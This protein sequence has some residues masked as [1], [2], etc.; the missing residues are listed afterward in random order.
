MKHFLK[1]FISILIC[2]TMVFTIAPLNGMAVFTSA[3]TVSED[4]QSGVEDTFN[5]G[6]GVVKFTGTG[7][8]EKWEDCS[9][10]PWYNYRSH[11]KSVVIGDGVTNI[12]AYVFYDCTNLISVT[13]PASIKN[14]EKQA[15]YNCTQLKEV[16]YGGTKAEWNKISIEEDNDCLLNAKIHFSDSEEVHIHSYKSTIIKD[17]TCT[18]SGIRSFTCNCGDVYTEEIAEL[19]HNLIQKKTESTCVKKGSEYKECSNCKVIFNKKDLPLADHNTEHIKVD[20]TCKTAGYEY[21]ICSVCKGIFNKSD[22]E[23]AEHNIKHIKVDST[24]KTAGYEYDECSSCKGIFNKKD[25]PIAK[26]NIK[27]IKFDSTCKVAG[28]EYDECS[29]CKGVFNK[30]DLPIADHKIKHIKVASTCKNVGYEYDECEVCGEKSNNKD[31]PLTDHSYGEWK[32]T[33]E[34]TCSASGTKAKICT[35]CGDS[36]TE[37]IPQL[38]HNLIQKTEESTC[39]KEGFKYDECSSCKEVFN[40]VDLPL[41]DHN[42]THMK[43][44][45]TCIAAGCEYDEC[46]VCGEKFDLKELEL[47]DHFW[48]DWEITTI[49]T[50]ESEGEE[51]R[52]CSVCGKTETRMI[53]K[54]TSSLSS[55]TTELV[56]LNNTVNGPKLTWEAVDEAKAYYVY[57][58]TDGKSWTRLTSTTATSYTDSSAKSGTNYIYTAKAYDDAGS[59]KYEDGLTIKYLTAPTVTVASNTT[60]G[61][62]IKW[63]KVTGVSRYYIY[64]KTADGSYK[65]IG[66][67]MGTSFTDK[68]APNGIKYYYTVRSGNGETLS[69][70]RAGKGLVFLTAPTVKSVANITTGVRIAWGKA[71]GVSGYHIYRK[72]SATGSYAKIG[73]TASTSFVDKTAKS[74]TTYYY[75]VRAYKSSTLSSYRAG[76]GVKYLTSPTISSV[77]NTKSGAKVVWGKVVGANGYCVYRK[78]VNGSYARVGTTTSTSFT[79]KTAKKG[80]TY[81]YTVRAVSGKVLSSYRAGSRLTRK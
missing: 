8:M 14:I 59:T 62:N 28:Y 22:L 29:D 40:R 48:G 50:T 25:L 10:T 71:S 12:S 68:T 20:S 74:G 21:D 23:I 11:V 65:N 30:I 24:C 49:P 42:K 77:T 17:A 19:G 61:A 43:N 52:A 57:R 33:A 5:V 15:F 26:H 72:T 4:S 54:L 45:S 9:S 16:F 32:T 79:D 3:K 80:T 44:D 13:I 66:N 58:R 64:R 38:D 7:S 6:T 31:L 76:V 56:A 73:T 39:V 63:D 69:S 2:V 35:V 53:E 36:I 37:T 1:K 18:T 67:T 47:T 51:T 34:P 78:T 55:K 75:T 60:S 81:Y 70:Y 41:A 27:H 46:T